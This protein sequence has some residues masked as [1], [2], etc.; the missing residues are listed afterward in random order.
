MDSRYGIIKDRG[1]DTQLHRETI[2]LYQQ[3]LFLNSHLVVTEENVR[4]LVG[5]LRMLF[6]SAERSRNN[7]RRPSLMRIA[8]YGP[9]KVLASY[10]KYA[11]WLYGYA[12]GIV[13]RQAKR[14]FDLCLHPVVS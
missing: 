2:I 5:N 14:G 3:K 11:R 4:S 7:H 9:F 1:I 6:H 13:A 8:S 12:A 10:N